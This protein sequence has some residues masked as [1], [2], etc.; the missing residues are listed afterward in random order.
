L[1]KIFCAFFS[2]AASTLGCTRFAGEIGEVTLRTLLHFTK[3]HDMSWSRLRTTLTSLPGC[4]S[5][6]TVRRWMVGARR[7][8]QII[9]L[10]DA[11]VAVT[12]V[13]TRLKKRHAVVMFGSVRLYWVPRAIPSQSHMTSWFVPIQPKECTFHP[14]L[15]IA[16]N[17]DVN[18][19]SAVNRTSRIDSRPPWRQQEIPFPQSGH[20]VSERGTDRS[21]CRVLHRFDGVG[22]TEHRS[23]AKG[24]ERGSLVVGPYRTSVLVSVTAATMAGS[25]WTLS[26][27][28][29]ATAQVV[30]PNLLASLDSSSV[31]LVCLL[32]DFPVWWSPRD[33]VSPQSSGGPSRGHPGLAP[34]LWETS[35]LH[36][37]HVSAGP[38]SR[39][40]V[41]GRSSSLSIGQPR[42]P[43]DAFKVYYGRHA[44]DVRGS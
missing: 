43:V 23:K 31:A 27:C 16:C 4:H 26:P 34:T 15:A 36:L 2:C 10:F 39:I 12:N 41:R 35:C 29:I 5:T 25:H 44:K 7:H 13:V 37:A 1:S 33:K 42:D 14:W 6:S 21:S 19:P 8:T 3:S 18:V 38:S 24:G 28:S 20:I 17:K 22:G 30:K 11:A 9:R 40:T 32:V